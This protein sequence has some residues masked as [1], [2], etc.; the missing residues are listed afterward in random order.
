M[1]YLLNGWIFHGYLSHNQMVYVE[2]SQLQH[3]YC[4]C[5]SSWEYLNSLSDDPGLPTLG[6]ENQHKG[7]EAF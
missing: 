3:L 6:G 1:V 2:Y 7:V 4:Q 5:D